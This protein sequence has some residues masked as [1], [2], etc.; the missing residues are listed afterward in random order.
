MWWR[1][2]QA[3]DI[4]VPRKGD[5]AFFAWKNH[6][7]QPQNHAGSGFWLTISPAQGKLRNLRIHPGERG[8]CLTS[9][10][11][12]AAPWLRI[13]ILGAGSPSC[14]LHSRDCNYI[15]LLGIQI[16]VLG[17]RCPLPSHGQGLQLLP[18]TPVDTAENSQAKG[19][20]GWEVWL[21]N[22]VV[23]D[24]GKSPQ[25]KCRWRQKTLSF[26]SDIPMRQTSGGAW[27]MHTASCTSY[28]MMLCSPCPPFRKAVA[29][30]VQIHLFPM[31]RA[32]STPRAQGNLRAAIASQVFSQYIYCKCCIAGQENWTRYPV[33]WGSEASQ[34]SLGMPAGKAAQG[35]AQIQAICPQKTCQSWLCLSYLPCSGPSQR[36]LSFPSG[37]C[38]RSREIMG[39]NVINTITKWFGLEGTLKTI[40]FQ[41]LQHFQGWRRHTCARPP[42][43]HREEFIPIIPS[44]LL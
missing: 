8:A 35:Q 10:G 19:V 42:H 4:Y 2:G 7:I 9:R 13:R 5:Q 43:P 21:G 33:V 41:P 17:A 29:T 24:K 1:G 16:V 39:T 26:G 18:P 32:R 22:G 28:G 3:W 11:Q 34:R 38:H 30:Q 40:L 27:R 37:M 20:W 14:S 25:S 36:L 44:L 12:S 6:G 23:M 15:P 31:I